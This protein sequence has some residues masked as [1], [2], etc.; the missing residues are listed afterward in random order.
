[1]TLYAILGDIHAN[2]E[3]FKAVIKDAVKRGATKFLSVGDLVGYCARPRECIA[4]AREIGLE[5]VLG[6]H[7]DIVGNQ[8]EMKDVH[9]AAKVSLEWTQIQVSD[10]D[11]SYLR[12]LSRVKLMPGFSLVHSS[13]YN[14]K[15]WYYT[16]QENDAFWNHFTR[17]IGL[18]SKTILAKTKICFAGHSHVPGVFRM[19]EPHPDRESDVA[20]LKLSEECE[21]TLEE[22]YWFMVNTGSVGQ[23]RDQDRRSCYI[24]FD[25]VT[26]TV[27]FHRVEYEIE[28][29][30]FQII[31]AGLPPQLAVRLFYGK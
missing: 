25:D 23:P 31:A 3:A 8:P 22:G 28:K 14:P 5:G 26:R 4:L 9:P 11:R 1:M 19:A 12:N 27:R 7:D 20:S 13:L 24:T 15:K 10:E 29:T 17:L 21:I 16:V 18:N 30:Q 6:N 2:E